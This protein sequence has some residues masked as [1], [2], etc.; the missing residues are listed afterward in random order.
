MT[1]EAFA[2]KW[3]IIYYAL[4]GLLFLLTGGWLAISPHQFKSYLVQQAETGGLPKLIR[5]ILKYWFLFTLP[6]LVLSFTPF[7]WT[8]LLFSF[9]SLLIVY[10][11]GSQLARWKQLRLVIKE[12]ASALPFFIRWMGVIMMSAAL[13]ILL[14]GYLKLLVLS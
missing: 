4:M 8:E 3:F 10:I 12:H 1:L 7:S 6:C 5:A 2:L 13:V 9:W 14:L 11:A